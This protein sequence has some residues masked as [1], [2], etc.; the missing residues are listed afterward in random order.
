MYILFGFQSVNDDVDNCIISSQ[1]G[2]VSLDRV[3]RRYLSFR[4]L[5]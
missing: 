2:F 4:L 3:G 5:S 1:W